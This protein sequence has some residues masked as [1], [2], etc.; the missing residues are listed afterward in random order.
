MVFAEL[1]NDLLRYVPFIDRD[2][3]WFVL[4]EFDVQ[5][6]N[7]VLFRILFAC[8]DVDRLGTPVICL[9]IAYLFKILLPPRR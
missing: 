1:L 7:W 2:F 4:H 6:K 9:L 5:N 8:E 3:L